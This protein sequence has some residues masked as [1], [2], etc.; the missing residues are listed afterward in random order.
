MCKVSKVCSPWEFPEEK[1]FRAEKTLSFL[2]T[3]FFVLSQIYLGDSEDSFILLWV[4]TA[5]FVFFVL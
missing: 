5:A 1:D 2:S 3:C 4:R